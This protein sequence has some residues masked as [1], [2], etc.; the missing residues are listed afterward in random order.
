MERGDGI[1]TVVQDELLKGDFFGVYTTVL[2]N[3]DVMN[4]LVAHLPE[5]IG[6]NN[7]HRTNDSVKILKTDI[8]LTQ[9]FILV[10]KVDAKPEVKE[11]IEIVKKLAEEKLSTQSKTK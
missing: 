3:S 5:A 9:P 7:V 6:T 11:L 10:S 8:T 2:R 4:D 1:R